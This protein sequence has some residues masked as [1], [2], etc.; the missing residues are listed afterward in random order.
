MRFG[1]AAN[2]DVSLDEHFSIYSQKPSSVVFTPQGLQYRNRLLDRIKIAVFKE[3]NALTHTDFTVADRGASMNELPSPS[4]SGGSYNSQYGD[5]LGSGQVAGS[6]SSNSSG[7]LCGRCGRY[8]SD[9]PAD[10][11][12][13]I[14]LAT[15]NNETLIFNFPQSSGSAK[16]SGNK[17]FQNYRMEMV[18]SYGRQTTTPMAAPVASGGSAQQSMA[19]LPAAPAVDPTPAMAALPPFLKGVTPQIPQ[20]EQEKPGA[21]AY[22]NMYI[23]NGYYICYSA[24]TG[25]V[26]GMMTPSGRTITPDCATVGLDLVYD[27]SANVRQ[28]WSKAD[29]LAD[30]VVTEIGVS[31]EIRVYPPSQVGSKVNGLYTFNGSPYQTLRIENPN[32]GQN[33]RVKVVKTING[34]T[35]ESQFEY[36]STQD[37]WMLISPDGLEVVSQTATWDYSNTV[38][39][40]NE[41]V[42]TASGQIA[43]KS[44]KVMRRY[45]FGER[46]VSV[47]LDPDGANLR[48][49]YTYYTN[50][51][52]PG[53]YGRVASVS[54]PDGYWEAYQYDADSR[55]ILTVSPW[56]N[57]AFNSEASKAKA[58]YKNFTP[59]DPRDEVLAD[60]IRPR[61]LEEKILG[62]TTRKEFQA[63]YF[64]ENN[65]YVE[66]HE[67]AIRQDAQYGDADNLRTETRYYPRGTSDSPSAGRVKSVLYP[68]KTTSTCTYEYGNW[69]VNATPAN[70]TFTPSAN[71]AATRMTVTYGTEEHPEGVAFKTTRG[72]TIHNN[73]GK[74]ACKETYVYTGEGYE[75]FNWTVALYDNLQRTASVMKSNN[76]ITDYTWNC[77]NL[78][79]KTMPDG[80]QYTYEYDALKRLIKETKVG[81]GN[82]PDLVTTYTYDA[83]NRLLTTTV[84]GGDLSMTSSIVYNLAGLP[85][86][87]T[88]TLGISTTLSYLVGS[89]TGTNLKG[90][91]ITADNGNQQSIVEVFC[92]QKI[93]S[94]TGNAQVA[95]FQNYGVTSEG[96]AWSKLSTGSGDSVRWQKKETDMAS[97]LASIQKSGYQG[98]TLT[99]QYQYNNLDQLIQIIETGRLTVLFA[100]DNLSNQIMQGI[101]L[102]S[103]GQLL[104]AA[105]DLIL[106]SEAK[107]IKNGS[108]WFW[109]TQKSTYGTTDDNTETLLTVIQEVLSG[110]AA[111]ELSK[112]IALDRHGNATTTSKIVN[113]A[114]K[115]VTEAVTSPASNVSEQKII[116]NGLLVSD[117]SSSNITRTFGY[118]GL[119]RLTSTTDSRTG[120]S[121]IAYHSTPGKFGLKASETDAAGN[122]TTYDYD[123]FGQLIE[124]KNALEQYTRYA[125]NTRGQI[126]KIWG[127]QY[128]VTLEYDN[129]GQQTRLTT[130]RNT[131][132][133]FFGAEFPT[134]IGDVTT[135]VYDNAS[136]LVTQK[137]D[138]E[139]QATTY[140]YTVTGNLAGRTWAR[141]ISTNYTY[142]ELD[143]LLTVDYSDET[144]DVGYTY[145]RLG[146][147]AGVTDATGTRTFD[148]NDQFDLTMETIDGI[149]NKALAR[150]YTTSG[151]KGKIAGMSIDGTSLYGYDYD[152][153]GR[154]NKITTAAGDFTYTRLANSDLVSQ[155]TRP[156]NMTTNWSYEPHRDLVTQVANGSVSVFDYVNNAIG[157]RTGMSRS[158]S[159]LAAPDTVSY[160][161]NNRNEVVGA[162]SD[163]LD[164]DYSFA[165]SYDSIGNRLSAD[166]A[167]E[168]YTYTSN[169]LNQYTRVNAES[170]TYDAD[171]NMLTRDGWTQVWN[172]ENRMIATFKG[173][174]RLEFDYDY[175]GRRIFKKVFD[176]DALTTH[177]RFVYDGY[178]LIRELDALNNNALLRS[179]VW[180][181][182]AVGLDVPLSVLD[183]VANQTYYYSLDANKNIAD[184]TA[185]NV[186]VVAHYEYTPFG[187]QTAAT[188]SYAANPFRFSSEY[189]D[190]ENELVYYNYREY[191]FNLGRWVSQDPI[192][193]EGGINLYLFLENNITPYDHLGQRVMR[194]IDPYMEDV[195]DITS[196]E[197]NR[198][199][200][201][202]EKNKHKRSCF[203]AGTIVKT[204]N[205]DWLIEDIKVND[206]VYAISSENAV[207]SPDICVVTGIQSAE[208]DEYY[209]L[210]FAP[211]VNISVTAEHPFWLED[212]GWV[213]VANMVPGDKCIT[214]SGNLIELVS[215]TLVKKTVQV[216]NMTVDDHHTYFVGS[217]GI[218]VHNKGDG[219]DLIDSIAKRFD[220][221]KKQREA[222][223][224]AIHNYKDNCGRGG[225]DNLSKRVLEELAQNAKNGMR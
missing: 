37:A 54:H 105:N 211:E 153:Y 36:S 88:N 209:T 186:T 212:K 214:I 62:I 93:S 15:G 31:Y 143:K 52:E 35:E 154:L 73:V 152:T 124:E 61:T 201:Q 63:F 80:T 220:L 46:P 85:V 76:E 59:L 168:Q 137:L 87:M 41:V 134:V 70:S 118:D 89:N 155:M 115:Q 158:G 86:Q 160:T 140:M 196:T 9:M 192:E 45:S 13:Q 98:V 29:G 74:V 150:T 181:P 194:P 50:K 22:F 18:D 77:C 164:T 146:Q 208:V 183:A 19:A 83:K 47:T 125:Y 161:Y 95:Q 198:F 191:D 179:Y 65:A 205:G 81:Y 10:T 66:I 131:T 67:V 78:A 193:E 92:D 222:F 109:C 53:S 69:N 106:K 82:Q 207:T 197:E 102:N 189:F 39:T 151:M 180:Q 33:S 159:A 127:A 104:P 23:G 157:N 103:D 3:N 44:S 173:S 145:T 16:L 223:S 51:S 144:P 203:L 216:F 113:R 68:N 71:G 172:G 217:C 100:Y 163:A 107:F 176:G 162:L 200:R 110:L 38:N 2:E 139:N 142:N 120:T 177:T 210:T 206:Q 224:E 133:D 167:G 112:V 170:P 199:N 108:N 126:T 184:L 114:Q 48:T 42:K 1:R 132:V 111:G 55:I 84:T 96:H 49:L 174:Q 25:E 175:M 141:G 225:N 136:G 122:T 202:D 215:K 119:E 130:Y 165:Y 28:V 156:N 149:Y 90:L 169:N 30:V 72:T 135:W 57:S 43:E 26:I 40:I 8:H 14:K 190:S 24:D 97:R 27:E 7:T 21:A 94:T 185:S 17:Y 64:D 204:P 128:P 121:A 79:S 5:Y 11:A 213:S 20:E 99:T 166:L 60:D 147:L 56:L 178:K 32:P 219:E 171:G 123:D 75:R 188:G 58:V 129:F 148:Y 221:T 195:D 101:D 12:G 218:W 6:G 138:A 116:T 182:D 34:I 187:R 4:L 91:T 117:R